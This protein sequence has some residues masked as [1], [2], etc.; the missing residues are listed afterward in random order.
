[1][2]MFRTQSP[3]D[4]ISVALGKRL[5]GGRRVNQAIYKCATKG[6]GSLN[7]KDYSEVR[8]ITY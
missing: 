3:G 5:K 6:T 8:K 4:G 1:M 2:G 7:I